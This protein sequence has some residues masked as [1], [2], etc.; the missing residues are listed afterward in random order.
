MKDAIR[1][2]VQSGVWQLDLTGLGIIVVLSFG[3]YLVGVAPSI[4]QASAVQSQKQQLVQETQQ[5]SALAASRGELT[6]RLDDARQAVETGSFRLRS[7]KRLNQYLAQL[8]KLATASKLTLHEIQ[9]GKPTHGPHYWS[10]PIIMSGTGRYRTCARFLH[11]LHKALPD[12]RLSSL[13]LNASSG[14]SRTPTANFR[15]GLVWHAA[16]DQ[17]D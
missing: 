17:Q 16:A 12:T 9:P 3:A 6:R 2:I 7:V 10:V 4:R 8:T 5:A 1:S 11:G 13:Q 14:D 15:F